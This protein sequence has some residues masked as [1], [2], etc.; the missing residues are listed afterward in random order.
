MGSIASKTFRA[1][2]RFT[3]NKRL[4]IRNTAELHNPNNMS[5][6]DLEKEYINIKLV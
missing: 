4:L 5:E 1:T 6:I 3:K 2:I